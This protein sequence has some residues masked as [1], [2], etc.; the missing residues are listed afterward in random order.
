MTPSKEVKKTLLP[1]VVPFSILITL[2]PPL[3]RSSCSKGYL[4]KTLVLLHYLFTTQQH[5]SL[6]H[7][8]LIIEANLVPSPLVVCW[9]KLAMPHAAGL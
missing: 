1:P 3:P 6:P 5:W 4:L 2:L 9:Q 8:N 7:F